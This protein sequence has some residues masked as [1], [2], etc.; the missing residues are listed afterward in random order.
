MIDGAVSTPAGDVHALGIIL[1]EMLTGTTAREEPATGHADQR[2]LAVVDWCA[3]GDRAARPSAESVSQELRAIAP[4]LAP[5]TSPDRRARPRPDR[6]PAKHGRR[7][8]RRLALAGVAAAVVAAA[9]VATVTALTSS[10]PARPLATVDATGTQPGA[11]PPALPDAATSNDPA[12][13]SEFIRY[14]FA[15]LTYATRTGDTAALAQATS[16]QCRD[17]QLAIEAIEASY[18]GGGALRGGAYVVRNVTTT[19]LWSPDRQVYDATVDRSPRTD[20]DA[21]GT[22]RA[23][24]PALSF[25]NCVLVLEWAEQRWRVRE[26]VSSGCVS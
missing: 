25:S 10:Q 15:A 1:L 23:T 3:L 13:G 20:V 6:G 5:A 7:R 21:A 4:G 12:G 18:A 8:V 22:A 11:S 16:A 19:D 14:W 24:L 9:A 17:C 26:V 2:L